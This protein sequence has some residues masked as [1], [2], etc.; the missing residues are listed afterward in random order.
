M[1]DPVRAW[2]CDGCKANL[3]GV[4]NR[5][6]AGVV[7][8]RFGDYEDRVPEEDRVRRQSS[9]CRVQT[10]AAAR[11]ATLNLANG[12]AR[13]HLMADAGAAGRLYRDHVLA[14]GLAWRWEIKVL[15][16]RSCW[17]GQRLTEM[18]HAG[19]VRGWRS[20]WSCCYGT[21]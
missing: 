12:P 18:T 5:V 14:D 21:N 1:G 19:Q 9:D 16:F 7:A 10:T 6:E 4:F 20:R 15:D 13:G 17:L 11:A 8:R 3:S 2:E